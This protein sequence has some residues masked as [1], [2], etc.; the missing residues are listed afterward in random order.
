MVAIRFGAGELNSVNPEGDTPMTEAERD[1]A[2]KAHG[3]EHERREAK[4]RKARW[5]RYDRN[6]RRG[7]A[8]FIERLCL[9]EKDD[10]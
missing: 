7:L 3:Q 2:I 6:K 5:A 9:L 4:S 10:R 1:A 8:V